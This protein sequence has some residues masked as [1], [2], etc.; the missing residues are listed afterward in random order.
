MAAASA[1]IKTLNA[2]Y[3]TGDE[4]VFFLFHRPRL[5]NPKQN[6]WMG[7]ER[8]RGKLA[9]FNQHMRGG[10]PDAFSTIIGDTNRLK[11]VRYVITLESDTVLPRDA[12]Y[13]LVG[14]IAHPLNRAYYDDSLGRVTEGYGIIQPRVGVSLT[15]AYR[16][17]FAAIHSGHPGVDPY[18]TAVSDVYQDLYGEGS[19]TGKGI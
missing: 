6:V 15:S 5:W 18:T 14:T 13:L 19:F 7:W 10:A 11:F 12:A 9:Q 17:Y 4:D 3:R 16:S 8:K 2:K 1:G